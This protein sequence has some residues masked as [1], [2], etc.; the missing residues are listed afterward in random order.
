MVTAEHS[1]L[2]QLYAA[3]L[4]CS[5]HQQGKGVFEIHPR[6]SRKSES[7]S[8]LN[9]RKTLII[10]CRPAPRLQGAA[11][12]WRSINMP[13][14]PGRLKFWGLFFEVSPWQNRHQD[15]LRLANRTAIH[16]L[17]QK[18]VWHQA[19]ISIPLAPSL[20][21]WVSPLSCSV[22]TFWQSQES[23]NLQP[24]SLFNGSECVGGCMRMPVQ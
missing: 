15:I 20:P 21:F 1:L 23:F 11:L 14:K 9:F 3:S 17:N 16:S 4:W 18:A 13:L 5:L 8:E 12:S 6:F 2:Q 22:L 24:I 10:H 7:L 19:Q